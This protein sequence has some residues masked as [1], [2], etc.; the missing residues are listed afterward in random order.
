[1]R[2]TQFTVD[3]RKPPPTS[4]RSATCPSKLVEGKNLIFTPS[5]LWARE[6]S[7]YEKEGAI[8]Q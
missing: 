8:D 4:L 2:V 5:P 1:M 3:G 7:R 6:M